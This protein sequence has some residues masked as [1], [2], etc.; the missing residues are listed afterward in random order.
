MATDGPTPPPCDKDVY[1]HGHTILHCATAGPC[2]FENWV[3]K[4]AQDSGQRVDWHYVGGL[5]AVLYI[6][7][8]HKVLS[9]LNKFRQE[10]DDQIA[11]VY[12]DFPGRNLWTIFPEEPSWQ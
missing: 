12:S 3:K 10:L 11:A 2:A 4:V 8:Y 7:D 1:G 5:A 6:G 9:S